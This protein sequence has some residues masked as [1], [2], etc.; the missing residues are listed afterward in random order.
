[1]V[2]FGALS[3]AGLESDPK[4]LTSSLAPCGRRFQLDA[5]EAL[6]YDLDVTVY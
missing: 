1:M 5:H 6:G 4:I 2:A 3:R